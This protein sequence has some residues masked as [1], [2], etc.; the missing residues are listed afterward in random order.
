MKLLLILSIF[1][2]QVAFGDMGIPPSAK[3]RQFAQS[4]NFTNPGFESGLQGWKECSSSG[5]APTTDV[6]ELNSNLVP[7]KN[8]TTP[9]AG[10]VDLKLS[11]PASDEQGKCYFT[12][13]TID[14]DQVSNPNTL[15]FSYKSANMVWG[16]L[17]GVTPSDIR[18]Y[19]ANKTTSVVTAPFPNTL[20][21]GGKYV[22]QWQAGSSGQTYQLILW[23]STTNASAW[24]FYADSFRNRLSEWVV[25]NSDSDWVSYTPTF[26]GFGAVSGLSARYRKQ[27]SN[28]ELEI[29]VTSGTSTPVEG[30]MTLPSGLTSSSSIPTIQQAGTISLSTASASQY[31]VLIETSKTYV[32]FGIQDG[33]SGGLTKKNASVFI[34]SPTAMSFQASIPIQGWTSGYA[35]PGVSAQRIPSEFT[36]LKSGTQAVTAEV[37]DI[38][39]GTVTDKTGS[40]NG[41]Q[42]TVKVPGT[43]VVDGNIGDSASVTF[44]PVVYVNGVST[45][46]RWATSTG[47][48]SS[49]SS[50]IPDLKVND[51]ISLRSTATHTIATAGTLGIRLQNDPS[52]FL[53]INR[54]TTKYLASNLTSSTTGIA[55]LAF[56]NLIVGKRY[57]IT[58]QMVTDIGGAASNSDLR[59]FHNSSTVSR[60]AFG[61]PAS[62]NSFSGS[63]QSPSF[64]ATA[65]TLTFNWTEVGTATLYG[66]GDAL[67]TYVTLT[68]LNN[69]FE[70]NF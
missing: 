37:T 43:Y 38:T 40:W 61:S 29:K 21:G 47:Q 56:N 31:K 11:K 26:T 1:L 49:G 54:S 48:T 45:N 32:T 66:T 35:T 39:F 7:T 44:T 58:T 30:Q 62:G 64:I 2:S 59:G 23:V 33:T 20:D 46:K 19:I 27:G 13:F 12:E 34:T 67:G 68:E 52:A 10:S 14:G 17:D 57:S 9:L 60:V 70:G 24:D 42:F 69:T 22:G 4:N 15:S 28:L 5:S 36:G 50:T 18:V 63:S 53:T 16:S 3:E 41:S 25:I 8:T 51:V 65:T 6:T 55:S